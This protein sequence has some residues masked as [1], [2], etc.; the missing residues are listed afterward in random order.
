MCVWGTDRMCTVGA[1]DSTEMAR[2]D[3]APGWKVRIAAHTRD[4]A[5]MKDASFRY[6][7][8]LTSVFFASRL[9]AASHGAQKRNVHHRRL[10]YRSGAH[11]LHN[12]GGWEE[13][14]RVNKSNEQVQLVQVQRVPP[15]LQPARES[16]IRQSSMYRTVQQ[17]AATL[18]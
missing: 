18:P 4:T 7:D 10:R 5:H 11:R 1:P 9:C 6:A 3:S 14:S 15:R 17:T 12:Y 13:E 16:A 2:D 8:A